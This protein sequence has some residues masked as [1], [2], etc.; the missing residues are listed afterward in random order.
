MEEELKNQKA[1]VITK[2]IRFAVRKNLLNVAL[3]QKL[4]AD[5]RELAK[6]RDISDDEDAEERT[7][8]FA[9]GRSIISKAT[10][11]PTALSVVK[12]AVSMAGGGGALPPTPAEAGAPVGTRLNAGQVGRIAEEGGFVHNEVNAVVMSGNRI[13][14]NGQK[15]TSNRVNLPVILELI[16]KFPSNK[17]QHKALWTALNKAKSMIDAGKGNGKAQSTVVLAV[18]PATPPKV[19]RKLKKA[20]GGGAE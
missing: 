11:E 13:M 8:T 9:G 1:S 3:A 5:L 4:D 14:V 10:G 19:V 18:P 2:F 17:K 15:L 7:Q 6:G 16:D 20:G 12:P